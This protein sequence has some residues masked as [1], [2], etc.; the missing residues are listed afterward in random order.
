MNIQNV[1]TPPPL[2]QTI[3]STINSKAI[4]IDSQKRDDTPDVKKTLYSLNTNEAFK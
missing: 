1:F 3:M 2:Q 4:K